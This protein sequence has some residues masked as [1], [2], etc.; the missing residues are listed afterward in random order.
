MM[1]AGPV[2]RA[3]LEGKHR[4]YGDKPARLGGEP[5]EEARA[6]LSGLEFSM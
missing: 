5:T 3:S 1:R 6:R 4:L 2:E